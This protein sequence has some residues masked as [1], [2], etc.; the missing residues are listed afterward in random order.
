MFFY[1]RPVLAFGYCHSPAPVS[2]CV[3]QSLARRYDNSLA[4]RSPNLD[5]RWGGRLIDFDLQGQILL[6]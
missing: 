6:L 3:Y 5:Q 4:V 1:P 2:V